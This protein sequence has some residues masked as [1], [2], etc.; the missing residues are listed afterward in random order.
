MFDDQ[1]IRFVIGLQRL[2]RDGRLIPVI[3]SDVELTVG[4]SKAGRKHL[5][6]KSQ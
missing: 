3:I 4:F 5:T 6:V 1:F 2:K